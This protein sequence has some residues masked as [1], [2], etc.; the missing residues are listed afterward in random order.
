MCYSVTLMRSI[1]LSKNVTWLWTN[2]VTQILPTQGGLRKGSYCALSVIF[3]PHFSFS[4]TTLLSRSVFSLIFDMSFWWQLSWLSF[5]LDSVINLVSSSFFLFLYP[6]FQ[7][8]PSVLDKVTEITGQG[9]L[10]FNVPLKTLPSAW[11][12]EMCDKSLGKLHLCS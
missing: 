8:E 5:D 1:K 11:P 2:N 7:Q 3:S 4:L 10:I 9:K 6:W 12:S